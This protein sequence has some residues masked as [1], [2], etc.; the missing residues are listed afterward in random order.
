MSSTFDSF[1][2]S[3]YDSY[4]VTSKNARGGSGEVIIWFSGTFTTDEDH[5]SLASYKDGVI[6]QISDNPPSGAADYFSFRSLDCYRS[7]DKKV[8]MATTTPT[9]GPPAGNTLSVFNKDTNLFEDI[10]GFELDYFDA[11]S[12]VPGVVSTI[13]ILSENTLVFSNFLEYINPFTHREDKGDSNTEFESVAGF[14]NVANYYSIDDGSHIWTSYV[15]YE[16]LEPNFSGDGKEYI[17]ADDGIESFT[18]YSQPAGGSYELAAGGFEKVGTT[19]APLAYKFH[20]YEADDTLPKIV[21]NDSFNSGYVWQIDPVNDADW[22]Q[23]IELND[24]I[25]GFATF[26]YKGVQELVIVGSF[27][28][29]N[30]PFVGDANATMNRVAI[31][32]PVDGLRALGTGFD[33]VAY[34]VH[35]D[36]NGVLLVGGDFNNLSDIVTPCRKMAKFN[37]E[38]FEEAIIGLTSPALGVYKMFDFEGDTE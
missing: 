13:N 32:N 34:C 3:G 18:C 7:F 8:L 1:D 6:K 30:S 15:Q 23:I 21:A 4:L 28:L 19:N 31:Y 22:T 27:T 14:D 26:K 38:D 25:E 16:S 29:G 35:V 37:G 10:T 12:R 24:D 17:L 9:G 36:K 5:V 2:D 20:E 33:G 11:S